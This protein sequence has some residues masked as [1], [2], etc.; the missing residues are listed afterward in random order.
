MLD[1][2]KHSLQRGSAAN[3]RSVQHCT[4]RSFFEGVL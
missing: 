2:T 4:R 3:S 1:F